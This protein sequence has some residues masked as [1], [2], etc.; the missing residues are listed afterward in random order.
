M[1][2]L[3]RS[4]AVYGKSRYMLYIRHDTVYLNSNGNSNDLKAEALAI[5][6]CYRLAPAVTYLDTVIPRHIDLPT[7]FHQP[8]P[9]QLRWPLSSPLGRRECRRRY[10]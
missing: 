2:D 3:A 1:G 5:K 10:L 6:L 8:L 7:P 4:R 9:A